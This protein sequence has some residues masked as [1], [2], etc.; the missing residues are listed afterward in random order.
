[1]PTFGIP[2]ALLSDHGANLLS[3]LMKDICEQLGIQKLNTT[4]YHPQC[5]GMVERF[6]RTLK[7]MLCA[8]AARFGPQW[9][10]Y[11][12]GVL[13]AYRNTPHWSTGEKPSYFLFGLDCR[14]PPEAM[15]ANP[16]DITPTDV[17]DYR[18]EFS[19]SLRHARGLASSMI[20]SA[21][22]WCK[23]HFDKRVC[24]QKLRTGDWILIHFPH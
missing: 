2:E 15:F 1:M 5:N 7:A 6:N 24:M 19:L 16:S 21:Q 11:L 18:E 23:K 13:Y 3:N 17:E 8:H 4:S 10:R 9:D 20:Q 14:T 22:K 12:S